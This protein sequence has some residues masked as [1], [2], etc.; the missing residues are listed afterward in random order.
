MTSLSLCISSYV[1]FEVYF[2]LVFT[3]FIYLKFVQSKLACYKLQHYFLFVKKFGEN[4]YNIVYS[5]A[6]YKVQRKAS[7]RQMNLKKE[8]QRM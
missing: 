5:N 4:L 3:A 6:F 7:I 8:T 1:L 2:D